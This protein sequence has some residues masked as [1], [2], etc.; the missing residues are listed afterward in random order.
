M[1]Y[2]QNRCASIYMYVEIISIV[3]SILHEFLNEGVVKR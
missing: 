1:S 2:T 3:V